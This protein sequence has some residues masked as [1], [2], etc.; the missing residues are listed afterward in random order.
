MAGVVE[1]L[2]VCACF[3]LFMALACLAFGMLLTALVGMLV[4]GLRNP[5]SVGWI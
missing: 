4:K 3:L 1:R 5:H 2:K